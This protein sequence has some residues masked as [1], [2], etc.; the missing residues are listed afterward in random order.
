MLAFFNGMVTAGDKVL[1]IYYVGSKL[2]FSMQDTASMLLLFAF[3]SVFAQ[4]VILKPLNDCIGERLILVVFFV[5]A[6]FSNASNGL[7]RTTGELYSGI[8]FASFTEMAFPAFSAIKANNVDV[9][10]QGRIQGALYSILSLASGLGPWMM[11]YVNHVASDSLL[12]PDVMFRF[13]ALLHIS[14]SQLFLPVCSPRKSP[15]RK[16]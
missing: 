2:L 4:G 13:A 3:G 10:E 9:S 14:S 8:F 16:I 15:T 1:I 11:G 5:A 6:V 12:G 7:A